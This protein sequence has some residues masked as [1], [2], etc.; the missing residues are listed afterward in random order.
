MQP[1]SRARG[2]DRAFTIVEVLVVVAIIATLIG[3]LVPALSAMRRTAVATADLS[4][5]RSLAAAHVA[6]M[7]M[8]GERF[9]DAGM[10]HGTVASPESSF[11]NRLKPYF[12]GNPVALRS[13]MDQSVHWPLEVGGDGIPVIDG[14]VPVYRS[15]S[16][17]MN[18]WLSRTYSPA[19][20][21]DGPG[22]GVDRL[23]QVARPERVVEFLLMAESG[24]FASADH[25]HA[26][27]WAVSPDPARTAASQAAIGA[28]DRERPGPDSRSN[29]A[30]V[31]GHVRTHEFRD[32][33]TDAARNRFDP[34]AP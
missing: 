21:L 26:E 27:D 33:F 17:G 23:A 34:L 22:A 2:G 14:P 3:I 15:T 24:S 6:Y 29:Y 9:I 18:N 12:G 5:L 28:V 11:V 1:H 16:Y 30:F 20:A 25:V 7:N 13:P 19:V 4:N 31:D 32:V 10:P 8:N